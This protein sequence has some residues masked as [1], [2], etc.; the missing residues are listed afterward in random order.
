MTPSETPQRQRPRHVRTPSASSNSY[1]D[2]DSYDGQAHHRNRDSTFTDNVR[3]LGPIAGFREWNRQRKARREAF[4]ADRTRVEQEYK[5]DQYNKRNSNNY[6]RPED[7]NG[8]R[9]SGSGTEMT[10]PSGPE[11]SRSNFH[12]DTNAPP[13]P[14]EA[15]ALPSHNSPL[16][17]TGQ[18]FISPQAYQLPPPPPGPPPQGLRSD[19]YG[20]REQFGSAYMP[21]GAVNPDPARLLANNTAANEG[22][23]YGRDTVPEQDQRNASLSPSRPPNSRSRYPRTARRGSTTSASRSRSQATSAGAGPSSS[24]HLPGNPPVA[25]K[26]RMANDGQHVELRRLNDQQAAAER[27][28]RRQIRR[29][30]RA[31]AAGRDSSASAIATAP[32]QDDPPPGQRYRRTST[33]NSNG[34][35]LTRP[36]TD[37]PI[38]NIPL[39][40]PLTSAQQS[41][42]QPDR[43]VSELNLPPPV[44]QH[45]S[46]TVSSPP[47]QGIS[48]PTAGVGQPPPN[49]SG[50]GSSPGAYGTDTESR[51]EG[52]RR[53]RR[54]ERA[55]VGGNGARVEFQ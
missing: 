22:S 11:T 15:G 20:S 38:T 17:N 50:I 25:I 5:E 51:A 43:R 14:V 40:P 13:L 1:D 35:P 34:A 7:A 16:G 33:S 31:A 8:R 54:A 6:P 49:E 12:P 48:P 47:F 19:G 29:D 39:P 32:T 28:S 10:G 23:A 9:E 52:N 3:E 55:R 30:R 21:Q 42:L 37:Q 46:H 18:T 44:P 4:R 27:E 26:M 2:R 36:S 45:N 24:T 41:P 53:R